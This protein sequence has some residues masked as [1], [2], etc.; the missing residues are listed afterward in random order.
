MY[1]QRFGWWGPVGQRAGDRD[2]GRVLL[3]AWRCVELAYGTI[4]CPF[5]L[6]L[7]GVHVL[8]YQRR[9]EY[10]SSNGLLLLG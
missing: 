5:L 2:R 9:V 3:A 1:G 4:L 6:Y 7:Y 10:H 8:V